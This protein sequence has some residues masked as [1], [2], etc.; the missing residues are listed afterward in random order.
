MSCGSL[1]LIWR[2]KEAISNFTEDT[3]AC[4]LSSIVTRPEPN[5]LT[6]DTR[7]TPLTDETRAYMREVTFCSTTLAALPPHQ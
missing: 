5:S 1:L 3:S 4:F 2:S 6:D 7:S